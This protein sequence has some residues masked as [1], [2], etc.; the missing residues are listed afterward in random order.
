MK[1]GCW[2]CIDGCCC[3]ENGFAGNAGVARKLAGAAAGACLACVG[4]SVTAGAAFE[5]AAGAGAVFE[6]PCA[7]FD[8]WDGDA[9][10][11]L[12]FEASA[13]VAIANA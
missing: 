10:D 13:A 8:A 12:T 7:C 3:W 5:E 2:D 6:E 1:A 4:G 9:R 11:P